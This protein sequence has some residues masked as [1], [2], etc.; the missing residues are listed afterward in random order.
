M[1]RDKESS[2]LERI[3][4]AAKAEF[5]EKGFQTASLRNIVKMAHVTTG[6]FYGYYDSKEDLFDALVGEQAEYILTLFGGTIDAFEKL[7]GEEQTSQMLE[8]SGDVTEQM[9]NYMY[10]HYDAFKLLIM[11]AEGTKYADFVHQIVK[12]EEASTYTYMETLKQMGYSV[13]PISQ[14]LIH[15]VASGMF[16]GIF[17][18][19]V[20]DMEKAEAKAYVRQ[21]RRFYAAGWE[22]LLGVKFGKE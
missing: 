9:M 18:S 22:E 8:I 13:E 12:R 19:I 14:K 1:T 2:T 15:M 6:A 5:L 20:H 11:C 7:T 3:H 4:T 10:E 16:S 21:L 17:E